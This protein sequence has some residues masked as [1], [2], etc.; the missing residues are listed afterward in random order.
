MDYPVP[1][2]GLCFSGGS[3]TGYVT[4][5]DGV[6]YGPVTID[7]TSAVKGLFQW[8]SNP[9][10]W[11]GG[12]K[13][14]SFRPTSVTGTV[15]YNFTN[16][17][18]SPASFSVGIVAIGTVIRSPFEST[19]V[20]VTVV[21][22]GTSATDN[23]TLLNAALRANPAV[24]IVTPG[25]YEINGNILPGT[26][27]RIVLNPGVEL[28]LANGTN[29]E[30]IRNY[31]SD[32]VRSAASW[33]AGNSNIII[34]GGGKLNFNFENN[35]TVAGINT[36][37]GAAYGGPGAITNWAGW[38]IGFYNVSNFII[39]DIE[40]IGSAY[41][42]AGSSAKYAIAMTGCTDGLLD[43]LK[44]ENKSDG[45]HGLGGNK[46]I[47]VTNCIFRTSD[48][49][50]SFC[51]ADYAP[52][53]IAGTRADNENI[54]VYNCSQLGDS[55][56]VKFLGC[57]VGG[58]EYRVRNCT[59]EK[60][61]AKPRKATHPAIYVGGYDDCTLKNIYGYMSPDTAVIEVN[62][63]AGISTDAALNAGVA[64]VSRGLKIINAQRRENGTFIVGNPANR[65]E[66]SGTKLGRILS[67]QREAKVVDIDI[68]GGTWL[69]SAGIEG[70]V[71]GGGVGGIDIDSTIT[72]YGGYC[73]HLRIRNI[74]FKDA[75]AANS[76]LVTGNKG[77]CYDGSAYT[78]NIIVDNV[79]V[80]GSTY[81]L[82][83]DAGSTAT[84]KIHVNN[85][86]FKGVIRPFYLDVTSQIMVENTHFDST[87]DRVFML[88][89]TNIVD[90]RWG[91]NNYVGNNS[92]SFWWSSNFATIV[93]K[94]VHYGRG[95]GYLAIT[96]AT[97]AS[98]YE[99]DV[100]HATT[101]TFTLTLRDAFAGRV[102]TVIN[103]GAGVV[104][105]AS[106]SGGTFSA[107]TVAAGAKTTYVCTNYRDWQVAG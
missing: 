96:G 44:I 95:Q 45:I 1:I 80:E 104:T 41:D 105:M 78:G 3:V 19:V 66:Y 39:R 90:I 98:V 54:Y 31:G 6:S 5:D 58:V 25:V 63:D 72:T 89:T 9:T 20:A 11:P 57:S 85:V 24:V 64:A 16:K 69:T 30:L 103:S 13:A 47:T 82:Y 88:A 59:A 55:T 99:A 91:A 79:H 14:V 32:G 53:I 51:P 97:T 43:M 50:A 93:P 46:R 70:A 60:I 77:L 87:T 62:H 83:F 102:V 92:A 107:G 52:Y 86:T 12:T 38:G 7:S 10:N 29:T 48:D 21:E 100:I 56:C 73:K 40:I 27:S 8:T 18:T 17:V 74:T 106:S 101:G 37:T 36:G 65:E 28:K 23:T 76:R 68:D 4:M 71:V 35:N 67:V 42:Y 2:D 94:S 75:N 22:L 34:E 49:G 61:Y 33:S 26:N 81:G 84:Y 15:N